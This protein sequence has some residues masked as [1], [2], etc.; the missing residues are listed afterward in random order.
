M[1]LTARGKPNAAAL[2][3]L[4]IV[5]IA[6]AGATARAAG[7]GAGDLVIYRVG[8]GSAALTS[9]ATAVS[10]DEY[11]T[12][13]ALVQSIALPTSTAGAALVASGSASSE[14]L[15][16]L[17]TDGSSLLVPGYFA[18]AGTA[19][20]AS[21]TAAAAPREV[22]VFD[23]T[24]TATST[25][26]LGSFF[27]G[28]NIRS[29]ASPDGVTIYAGS[30]VTAS[31]VGVFTAGTNGT[32]TTVS[33]ATNTRG[34]AV[35]NGQVFVSSGSSPNV[36][37]SLVGTAAAPS[38]TL[39]A[40]TATDTSPYEFAFANTSGTGT[41]PDTLY[42]ADSTS[43]LFKYAFNAGTDATTLVG[44]ATIPSGVTGLALTA[45]A[46]GTGEN[47]YLTSPTTL[48]I[49]TDAFS[50]ITATAVAAETATPLA[51]A[52]TNEAFRGVAFA[53]T[54]VAAPEPTSLLLMATA[55]APLAL[56]RRRRLAA[57]A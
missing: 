29:A 31:G 47:L 37:V 46:A 30:G 32:P 19:G 16:S 20:I 50:A 12:A 23:A 52:S 28:N 51:T 10:L 14:G 57:T 56:G 4:F 49:L 41:T 9:A 25:T 55:A 35:A 48:S 15:L 54:A 33:G 2:A 27:S 18:N 22:A 45:N 7:F 8:T 34:V 17:S 44:T 38:T 40:S 53:P 43:K 26:T 36:G 6:A 13:G 24:G 42:V 1:S 39:V 11:T 21:T 3:T 5:P